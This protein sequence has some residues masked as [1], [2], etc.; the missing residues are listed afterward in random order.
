MTDRTS[1]ADDTA[2]DFLAELDAGQRRHFVALERAFQVKYRPL[3]WYHGVGQ[4]VRGLRGAEDRFKYGQ[5][6]VGK[7]AEAL[8]VSKDLLAKTLAFVER[9]PDETDLAELVR[10]NSPWS[11]VVTTLAMGRA[12]EDACLRRQAQ[13]ALLREAAAQKW[14]TSQLRAVV[15]ERRSSQLG[16]DR[17]RRTG[18]PPRP[19]VAPEVELR[20]LLRRIR[21]LSSYLD[22]K[23]V[24]GDD[25]LLPCLQRTP[26]R[27]MSSAL[28]G[29]L[30]Q[31]DAA[32]EDVSARIGRLRRGL[33]EMGGNG[34]EG[35]RQGD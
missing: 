10:L 4:H 11:A 17:P 28:R 23:W 9:F 33:H 15:V 21:S 35:E 14:S 29:L 12:D 2:D 13:L 24:K 7:A 32:L 3:R 18:R 6:L 22:V 30:S 27:Q 25:A 1:G 34:S 20:T 19:P 5:S 26:R 16:T 8:K 31:A